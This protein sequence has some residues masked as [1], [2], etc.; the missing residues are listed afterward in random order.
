MHWKLKFL[1]SLRLNEVKNLNE[2]YKT[3]LTENTVKSFS[4]KI[5]KVKNS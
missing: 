2:V 5:F 3:C 1:K 4:L